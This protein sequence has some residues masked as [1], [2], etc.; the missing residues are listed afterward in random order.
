MSTVAVELLASPCSWVNRLIIYDLPLLVRLLGYPVA[1]LR[2]AGTPMVTA[3]ILHIVVLLRVH[4]LILTV[5]IVVAVI[6]AFTCGRALRAAILLRLWLVVTVVIVERLRIYVTT[7]FAAASL[8]AWIVILMSVPCSVS[9]QVIGLGLVIVIMTHML[10]EPSRIVLTISWVIWAT[11]F[12][13][14]VGRIIS[15][16]I[17]IAA[18]LSRA[19]AHARIGRRAHIVL[20]VD[21]CITSSSCPLASWIVGLLIAATAPQIAE[22]RLIVALTPASWVIPTVTTV[23]RILTPLRV[24]WV[25]VT[26]LL[27]LIWLVGIG[28]VLTLVYASIV[29]CIVLLLVMLPLVIGIISVIGGPFFIR[30]IVF[31]SIRRLL[32]WIIRWVLIDY[33]CICLWSTRISMQGAFCSVCCDRNIR[34]SA[35][36]TK[37]VPG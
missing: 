10:V 19:V 8:V 34:S 11:Y 20:I 7:S 33:F 13:V 36:F 24:V 18:V 28:T 29:S 12:T 5:A 26:I 37:I 15:M 9:R 4:H 32:E 22:L 23:S 3:S 30:S 16:T 1:M 2:I 35:D 14:L 27:G 25:L 31:L 6:V 21:R 17:G